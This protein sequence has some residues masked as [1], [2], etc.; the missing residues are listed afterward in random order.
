MGQGSDLGLDKG[1]GKLWARAQVKLQTRGH[2]PI[3]SDISVKELILITPIAFFTNKYTTTTTTT[4]NNNNNNQ[5]NNS[6]HCPYIFSSL[7]MQYK[8]DNIG[9]FAY[10]EKNHLCPLNRIK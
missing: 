3:S 5:D 6:E 1:S 9:H 8:D 10:Y 2:L 4:N 7:H